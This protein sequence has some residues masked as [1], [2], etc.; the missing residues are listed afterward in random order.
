MLAF[1]RVAMVIVCFHSSRTLTK[2]T[3]LM[4][5]LGS[6]ICLRHHV[7]T[8]ILRD[9]LNLGQPFQPGLLKGCLL[10]TLLFG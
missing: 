4:A 6:D 8:G 9:H 5:K 7:A 1:V 3:M 2:D 10:Q